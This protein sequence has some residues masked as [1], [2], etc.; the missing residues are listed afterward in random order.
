MSETREG[1]FTMKERFTKALKHIDAARLASDMIKIPSYSFMADQEKEI[2]EYIYS[3]FQQE[4]IESQLVEIKPGRYNVYGKIAGSGEGRSL[5]LSG[6]IDTVPA[7]DMENA[8]SGRIADGKI[9]GRGACD[10]KG[11]VAAMIAVLIAFQRAEITLP[12]DIVFAGL[13]DEEEQGRGVE[14]LVNNGPICDGTIMGEPTDM[15]IAIGHKGLE[16]IDVKVK[17]HKVHGGDKEHGIN[18]IEMAGR[19]IN[20][21]YEEYVPLLNTRAYPVLGAP[22]INIGRIEGG[23]QPSTVAGECLIKLDRRCVPTETITQVYEELNQICDALHQEDCHFQAKVSDVFEGENL[24]PHIPFCIEKDDPLVT[25]VQAAMVQTQW[26]GEVTAFPA[27]SDA[28]AISSVTD[29]KC[30]VMG[31]GDLGVAH[32]IHE[33]IKVEDIEMAA[34][35]Y[36]LTAIAYCR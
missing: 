29:S 33:Y 18:A 22:T 19:F 36:G 15:R 20:R 2:A 14:Y 6:H 13:A 30:I 9:Y 4:G 24:L 27:W 10:M 7:Y 34:L 31:P 28:G 21:I 17:G 11:P 5:M 26:K 23:D 32:S 25:S 16:W 35:V 3:V 8:F 12:G 1:G